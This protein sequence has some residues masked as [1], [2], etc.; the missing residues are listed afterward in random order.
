MTNSDS[1]SLLN[2]INKSIAEVK[3]Y[4]EKYEDGTPSPSI[5]GTSKV[6]E[7][8]KERILSNQKIEKYILQ[9]VHSISVSAVK[10]YDRTGLETAIIDIRRFMSNH[11]PEFNRVG[12]LGPEFPKYFS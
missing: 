9:A 7:R 1:L 2:L 4:V 8:L 11:I 6:L 10:E 5:V 12:P 3:I